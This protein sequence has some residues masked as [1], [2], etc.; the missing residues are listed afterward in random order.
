MEIT[1]KE[2]YLNAITELLEMTNDIN[3]LDFVY[4]TLCKTLCK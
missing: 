4:K 2:F 3:F 1:K